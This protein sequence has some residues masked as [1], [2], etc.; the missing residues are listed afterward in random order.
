MVI[1]ERFSQKKPITYF[2][3]LHELELEF[4]I[5]ILSDTWRHIMRRIPGC[6]K[7]REMPQEASR[8]MYDEREIEEY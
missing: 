6:K 3:L 7:I 8:V 5:M 4:G 1:D 2:E